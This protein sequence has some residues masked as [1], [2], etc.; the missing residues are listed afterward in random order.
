MV[1]TPPLADYIEAID[2]VVNVVGEDRGLGTDFTEDYD[3]E[4]FRWITHDK[5]NARELTRFDRS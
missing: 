1:R 4:F 5:G 3:D 2:Y